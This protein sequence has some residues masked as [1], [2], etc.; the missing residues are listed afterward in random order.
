MF[1]YP[2]M[3]LGLLSIS[4]PVIIHLLNKRRYDRVDWAAMRFLRL[5]SEQNQRRLRLEDIV[6]LLLRCGMLALIVLALARP[7]LHIMGGG[8]SRGSVTAVIVI[9]N[10]SSM[11]ATDGV[12]SRFQNAKSAASQIIDGL[13]AGSS[14]AVMLASNIVDPLI[15]DP[16]FDLAL[17]RK[18]IQNSVLTDRSTNLLPAFRKAFDALKKSPGSKEVYVITD[19]QRGG[20]AQ[21]S[22]I[23]Q[24]L[25]DTHQDVTTRIVLVGPD[26]RQNAGVSDLKVAGDLTPVD[27]PLRLEATITNY[28]ST[29]I[30]NLPVQLRIDAGGNTTSA[31][32]NEAII[33]ALPA[34]QSQVVSLFGKLRTAGPHAITAW[35]P[36]DHLPADDRRTIVVRGI[37]NARILL[38]DGDNASEKTDAN[39]KTGAAFL[40]GAL[41]PIPADQIPNYFL[42]ITTIPA[43]DLPMTNLTDY[44]AVITTDVPSFDAQ[45]ADKL[46]DYLHHGGGLIVFPGPDTAP[47]SY[48]AELAERLHLLPAE[49]GTLRGDA[50]QQEQ[51]FTLQSDHFDHPIAAIWNDA[52]NGSPAAAHFF[53][54]FTLQPVGAG[55]PRPGS[56]VALKSR[57]GA[58]T[59]PLRQNDVPQV[60]LRFSD[61]SPA[62]MQRGN[63]ILFSS[64][65]DT[66]WNDL[67]DH[68]GIFLP[69]IYRS[70]AS[71][72]ARG[73][74]GLNVGVGVPFVASIPIDYLGRPVKITTPGKARD[75]TTVVLE[76]ESTVVRCK[77]TDLAG[78]YSAALAGNNPFT[79]QFAA[80][81]EANES[82]LELLTESEK[83]ALSQA[84]TVVSWNTEAPLNQTVGT[85]RASD[86]WWIPLAVIALLLAVVEPF[87]ANRFSEAK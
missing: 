33:D 56:D 52:V 63:V 40:R 49:L 74:A 87:V 31:A 22:D 59:P 13:P 37:S 19:G 43:S 1:L 76:G 68:G 3:L 34:G 77:N 79:L 73:D 32:E 12:S 7:V 27:R 16:T 75:D 4:I 9:D 57:E 41:L 71:I 80:Q 26:V 72:L 81:A 58:E 18:S 44:A 78:A 11:S 10:S 15:P 50:N 21:L 28:G 14:V 82:R 8:L 39:D 24:T 60:V 5:A 17:A 45:T 51:F 55:S 29:E 53:R 65:A 61:G 84:A 86:D 48:N 6:L 62:I 85:A 38:V 42:Q 23:Q 30:R 64:T 67:P 66:S 25:Q 20:W 54:A 46:A 83:A 70:L 36:A 35:I 47:D 2:S 69:L